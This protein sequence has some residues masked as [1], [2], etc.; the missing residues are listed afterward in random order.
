MAVRG[1]VPA[2]A[3]QPGEGGEEYEADDD[4]RQPAIDARLD[5]SIAIVDAVFAAGGTMAEAV[6]AHRSHVLA[7]RVS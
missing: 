3:F 7:R 5:A 4:V 6:E 1:V 2:S